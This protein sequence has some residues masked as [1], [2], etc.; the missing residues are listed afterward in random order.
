MIKNDISNEE[1]MLVFEMSER[2]LRRYKS[3][4]IKA[5]KYML[6]MLENIELFTELEVA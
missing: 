5:K 3:G 4:G 2:T 1:A 6:V